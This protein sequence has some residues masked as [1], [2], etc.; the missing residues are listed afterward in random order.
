M[1]PIKNSPTPQI[2]QSLKKS[3]ELLKL[4]AHKSMQENS[5][6]AKVNSIAAV[7]KELMHQTSGGG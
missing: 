5:N 2:K 1:D 6:K 3:A 4:A 7:A